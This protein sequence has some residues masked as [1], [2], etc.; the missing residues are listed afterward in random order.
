[1]GYGGGY[2]GPSLPGVPPQNSGRY[3]YGPSRYL[4]RNSVDLYIRIV[5]K[6]K[7]K[8]TVPTYLLAASGMNCSVQPGKI[9]AKYE[10]NEAITEWLSYRI[11]FASNPGSKEYAY[12][13]WKDDI[14]VVH[15]II[16]IGVRN[17]AGRGVAFCIDGEERI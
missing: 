8:G 11:M 3:G 7:D 16:V 5:V 4:F 14:G 10:E 17:E 9:V 1:M 2:G 15:K 13:L 12:A 6:D